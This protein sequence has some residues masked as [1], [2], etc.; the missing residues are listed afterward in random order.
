MTNFKPDTEGKWTRIQKKGNEI[1]K[2]VI[3]YIITDSSTHQITS[4]VVIDDEKMFTPY[5]SKTVGK[6]KELIFTDHCSIS[7]SV[8]ILQGVDK[9]KQ[10]IERRKIWVIDKDGLNK[11]HETTQND[12]G[13]GDMTRYDDPYDTWMKSVEH[14]MHQCFTRRTV[15][16]GKSKPEKQAIKAKKIRE[17]LKE[18][19]KR[20]KVQREIVKLYQEKL[21]QLEAE[22]NDKYRAKKLNET[23]STLTTDDVLSPNAF[24]KMK[25]SISKNN[26]LQ[27]KAVYKREGGTATNENEIKDE[28]RK[29]FEHRLRNRDPAPGWEGYVETTNELVETLLKSQAENKE[30]FSQD[31]LKDAIKKIFSRLTLME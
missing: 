3:D 18:T 16:T 19:A 31:E 13:L 25:K 6:K 17:I 8:D 28:V 9:S 1:C 29:E 7:A 22:K 23:V 12:I 15:V 27:L 5:R 30:P 2:S 10:K 26:T 4:N 14:L 21:Q 11:F 24:W 20:G